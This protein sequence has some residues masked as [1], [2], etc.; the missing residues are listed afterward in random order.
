MISTTGHVGFGPGISKIKY[1][2]G[3]EKNKVML[4][5]RYKLRV[6]GAYMNDNI[7]AGIRAL[8]GVL[9][10]SANNNLRIYYETDQVVFFFSYRFLPAIT[11][12]KAY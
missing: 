12:K 9:P 6:V 2:N 5:G 3:I 11:K 10:N 4:S 1:E 7:S 8:V